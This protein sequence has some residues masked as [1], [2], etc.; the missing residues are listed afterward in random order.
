[1][2]EGLMG[3]SGGLK[4]GSDAGLWA[5]S[6]DYSAGSHICQGPEDAL[7][8]SVPSPPLDP[9]SSVYVRLLPTLLMVNTH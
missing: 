6:P 7:K 4:P 1:M 8:A 9:R 2:E 3:L 5:S